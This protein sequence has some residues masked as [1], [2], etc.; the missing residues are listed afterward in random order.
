MRVIAQNLPPESTLIE[1]VFVFINWGAVS[2]WLFFL[3]VLF[4]ERERQG[5][6]FCWKGGWPC[7]FFLTS[8]KSSLV[9]LQ[10]GFD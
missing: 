4:E 3:H 8:S 5:L 6:F 10:Y 9:S 2:F 1:K 7:H